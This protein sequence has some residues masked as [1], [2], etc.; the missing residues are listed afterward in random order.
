MSTTQEFYGDLKAT[1]TVSENLPPGDCVFMV[2]RNTDL[3]AKCRELPRGYFR[4]FLPDGREVLTIS[5]TGDFL[6]YGNLV[7]NDL[8]VYETFKAFMECARIEHDRHATM[9]TP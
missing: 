4:F 1:D 3:S 5:P 8:E 6:V 9:T 7:A 2:G